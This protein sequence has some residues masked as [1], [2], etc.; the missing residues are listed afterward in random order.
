MRLNDAVDRA[1]IV[2]SIDLTAREASVLHGSSSVA[3]FSFAT[4]SSGE[5]PRH[6]AGWIDELYGAGAPAAG[7]VLRL[8]ALAGAPSHPILWFRARLDDPLEEGESFF[9]VETQKAFSAEEL[10]SE[11]HLAR[12][13]PIH[14]AYTKPFEREPGGAPGAVY[15]TLILAD[16]RTSQLVIGG[17]GDA[18]R[19]GGARIEVME[20]G[21]RG[22]W[23]LR[24]AIEGR[25]PWV[26]SIRGAGDDRNVTYES[27]LLGPP[28]RATFAVR[29]P[30]TAP[31]FETHAKAMFAGKPDAFEVTVSAGSETLLREPLTSGSTWT[32]LRLPLS[33]YAGKEIELSIAV[34]AKR[35]GEQSLIA[36][37]APLIDGTPREKRHDVIVVSLDTVRADHV[38]ILGGPRAI[39]PGFELLAATA[40]TFEQTIAPAPWTLP[41][42]VSIFSGQYPDRHGTHFE[43]S[44]IARETPWLPEDLRRA[45]FRTYAFTGGGYVDP[46]FGFARGFD[47]YA[48]DDPSFPREDWVARRGGDQD[49]QSRA[50]AASRTRREILDL[51]ATE[52]RSPRFFFLHTYAAHNYA[53]SPDVLLEMGATP[54]ELPDL[55]KSLSTIELSRAYPKVGS[56][57]EK[58][59]IATRTRFLYEAS[60]RTA[61]AF[62]KDVVETL[63]RSGRADSTVLVVLSDHGEEL[64]ER[65]DVGHHRQSLHE[66][67]I[68]V[69]MLVRAAGFEARRIP[70]VVSLVD[71]A[72]TLRELFTLT[73]PPGSAGWRDLQDGR[74]LVPLL[75][76]ERLDP[77]A[78]LAR[79]SRTDLDQDRVL[80][81]LRGQQEKYLVEARKDGAL[82][83]SL[84]DLRADPGE[85][86]NLAAER[87]ER[88]EKMERTLDVM[89]KGLEALG[90]GGTT[91]DLSD[92]MVADLKELGYLGGE[93]P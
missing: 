1:R 81:A 16:P 58:R 7:R 23:L 76:G 67:A 22:A 54:D 75:R 20:L 90:P 8:R 65:G 40:A 69:P 6:E 89:V 35:G 3:A 50:R 21:H 74:S 64:F 86:Q 68:H 46:E 85:L 93:S 14:R 25:S 24:T 5:A 78:S 28:G 49:E 61:D 84:F 51:L 91:A 39:T 63:E 62:L 36:F 45:G 37:G 12:M 33:A 79:G 4:L 57:D 9:V 44:R 17:Y 29:V 73:A 26:R 48:T 55:L 72:P 80:R 41:S 60:V 77:R 83:R 43:R 30:A 11:E 38:S 2:S 59:R 10:G 82:D 88:A 18:A 19:I 52:S 87:G 32:P 71:V 34:E 13:L 31:V 66:E 70:D 92:E 27:L 42:H 53:A 56:D 47:R 15:S